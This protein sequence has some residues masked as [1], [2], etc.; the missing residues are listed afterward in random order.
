MRT[1]QLTSDE[2]YSSFAR[3]KVLSKAELLQEY[4]CSPM[5]LWRRLRQVGYLTSYNYNAQYY[6]LATIPQ[7]DDHGLWTYRDIRFSQWGKLPETM[8]A[9]IEG[10]PGG[11]T[12]QEVAGFLHV[13]NAKPLLTHLFFK[14]RLWREAWGRSF[15]YLAVQES[16]QE[17]QLRRRMEQAPVP[18]LPEPPQIIALLVEMIRHPRWTP[19]QWSRRLARSDIHLGTQAINAVMDHYHLALKKGL[20]SS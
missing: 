17:Q 12:A 5:T 14:Q 13:R 9:V 4:G 8:V 19:Q 20:L 1:P 7:F 16:Q 15:V 10:S 6:T 2:V 18:L 3:R 11:M